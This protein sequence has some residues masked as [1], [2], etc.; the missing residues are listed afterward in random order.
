MLYG[1]ALIPIAAHSFMGTC[2]LLV[3]GKRW[4]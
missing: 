4:A 2:V 3:H 1:L